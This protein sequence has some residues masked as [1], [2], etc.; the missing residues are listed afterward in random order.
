MLKELI[1]PF[2]PIIKSHLIKVM[3]PNVNSDHK[4]IHL[5]KRIAPDA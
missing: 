4:G 3:M 1:P 5:S 2:P